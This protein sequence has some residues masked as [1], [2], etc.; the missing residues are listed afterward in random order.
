MTSRST[1]LFSLL[2]AV[3]LVA[4]VVSANPR[5]LAEQG[6]SSIVTAVKFGRIIAEVKTSDSAMD[7]TPCNDGWC[8]PNGP[9]PYCCDGMCINNPNMCDG[10]SGTGS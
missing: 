1:Q 10:S 4:E 2:V 5:R 3:A 7:Y 8:P 9:N 6:A